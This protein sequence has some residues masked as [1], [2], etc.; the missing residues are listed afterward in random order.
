MPSAGRAPARRWALG[1]RAHPTS[2]LAALAPD[3]T[4]YGQLHFEHGGDYSH[5]DKPVS[6][7][8]AAGSEV[9]VKSIKMKQIPA[10]TV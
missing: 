1:C 8:S 9:T 7:F 6:I 5:L 4:E 3:G 10:G 2:R